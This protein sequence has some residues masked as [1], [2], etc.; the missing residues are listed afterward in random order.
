MESEGELLRLSIYGMFMPNFSLIMKDLHLFNHF[1]SPFDLNVSKWYVFS[2]FK[3]RVVWTVGQTVQRM[4][5][6]QPGVFKF[7][8]GWARPFSSCFR[9]QIKL[10]G[11]FPRQITV[12]LS[13]RWLKP[14]LTVS[15]TAWSPQTPFIDMIQ[16]GISR[17]RGEI[18]LV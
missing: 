18:L 9:F 16:R 3:E 5:R 11:T 4:L 10:P 2:P 1:L 17:E 8:F 6:F 14:V 7:L 15:S 12:A 13:S